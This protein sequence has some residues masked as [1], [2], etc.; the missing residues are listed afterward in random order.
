MGDGNKLWYFA[1]GSNMHPK[2]L[3]GR[4]KVHP[5]QSKPGYIPDQYLNFDTLGL[6]YVEPSFA[7][8]GKQ[9]LH[10]SQP[11]VHGVAHQ[12]TLADY[13][14]IRR[15]EGG[16][17]HDNIGYDS[18]EVT[19][20]CYDGQELSAFTLVQCPSPRRI[21]H[22]V[23]YPSKRYMKLIEEG[24]V[25]FGLEGKYQEWLKT[26]PRYEPS[27]TL[28]HKMGKILYLSIAVLFFIPFVGPILIGRFLRVK[29][30]RLVYVV[31]NFFLHV[32]RHVY[33]FAFLPIFGPGAGEEYQFSM[34]R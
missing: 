10:P 28:V 11:E 31:S 14:Q 21:H 1:Y 30:P 13:E 7:S 33:Y 32:L 17:G 20:N 9:P 19:V 16:G 5:T 15:T 27:P 25:E 6:P 12:I 3:G 29:V 22:G 2:I 4:R 26:L 24:S 18:V 23:F 8:I 34:S